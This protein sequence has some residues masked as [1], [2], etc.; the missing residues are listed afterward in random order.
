M[1]AAPTNAKLMAIITQL[2]AQVNALQNVAPAAAAASP[3]GAA[4]VVFADMP[5][6]LGTNDLIDYS[7]KRGSAI[8]EQGCKALNDRALT[9]G[10]AMTPNQTVIFVEA[11]HCH[12]T[13]MAWNQGMRQITTFT[14]ST[15]HQVDIIKSYGQI[16]KA[17]LKNA[18]ERLC[19]PGE[20][21]SQT[22]TKENNTI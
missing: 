17:T 19:K 3:A 18:C 1:A 21:D 9:D 8:F 14:N 4:L 22:R 16:D 15:G 11:F 13:T 20:P 2:Q 5:Q 6:T 7:M 10:F 12:A